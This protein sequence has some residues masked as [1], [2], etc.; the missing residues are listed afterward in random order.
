MSGVGDYRKNK[1]ET[2]AGTGQWPGTDPPTFIYSF[3]DTLELDTDHW[4]LYAYT[5]ISPFKNLTLTV[6]ASGDF[7][8]ENDK[9]YGEEEVDKNQFNPKF[10]VSWNPVPSTTIRGA[11]FR[12]LTRTLVTNQTL[13][14]TQVAGFNQF[15]D[16]PESTSAWVYGVAL[17]Q[18][19]PKDVYFGAEFSYRDLNVPFLFLNELDEITLDEANWEEYFGRAYLYWTPLD[20]LALKA[21]YL[22]EDFKRDEKFPDGIKDVKTQR[23]P[24]G[25]NFFHPSGLSAGLTATYYNQKGTIER[26]VIAFDLFEDGSDQFWLVDAAISY[27]FPKRFGFVT[28]GVKNLFDKKFDYYEVDRNNLR[29]QQDTQVFAKLTLAFP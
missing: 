17:D 21:E 18:K 24:L 13:E 29:I 12:T 3:S 25:I 6:G 14:P 9:T 1:D 8:N 20:W 22:Y 11:V 28:L 26:N 27:R 15:F 5:Y 16:D 23:V 4:N 7:Y 2:V 10:G 19:F